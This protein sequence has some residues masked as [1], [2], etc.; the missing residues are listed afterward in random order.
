MSSFGTISSNINTINKLMP[1]L[2]KN[3][4]IILREKLNEAIYQAG[5][6]Y[7]EINNGQ[8]ATA[9]D[10]IG[11]FLTINAGGLPKFFDNDVFIPAFT[12]RFGRA[13]QVGDSFIVRIENKTNS[14]IT[15]ITGSS[16]TTPGGIYNILVD[17]ASTFLVRWVG[18]GYALYPYGDSNAP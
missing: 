18:D 4:D 5:G 7:V 17:R 9:D 10:F 13:P 14:N 12:K 16:T 8:T 1:L 15:Q 11:G 3:A 2:Y 6:S